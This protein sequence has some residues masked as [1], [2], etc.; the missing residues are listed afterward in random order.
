[1]DDL[2]QSRSEIFQSPDNDDEI[3]KNDLLNIALPEETES[4]SYESAQKNSQENNNNNN[5]QEISTESC[6]YSERNDNLEKEEIKEIEEEQEHIV[7]VN[8][9]IVAAFPSGL[10][11]FK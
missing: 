7:N 4:I 6:A 5:N 2:S 11:Y 9:T 3:Q 1:M 10:Y 8:V